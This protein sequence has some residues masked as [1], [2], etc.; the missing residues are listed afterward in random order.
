MID[1]GWAVWASVLLG[2][3]AASPPV[4]APEPVPPEPPPVA[5][6][7]AVAPAPEPPPFP[8]ERVV[9]V[10]GV[11][12]GGVVV[13][14]LAGVRLVTG[15][16]TIALV[17][18]DG[19]VRAAHR[20]AFG[21]SAGGAFVGADH[22]AVG[23]ADANGFRSPWADDVLRWDLDHDTLTQLAVLGYLPPSFAHFGEVAVVGID[24]G[25]AF[26][27]RGSFEIWEG[28][29]GTVVWPASRPDWAALVAPETD[30]VRGL[31]VLRA[32]MIES[33][34]VEGTV[35][36]VGATELAALENE[37]DGALRLVRLP[38][39]TPVVVEGLLPGEVVVDTIA[40][41]DLSY[42]RFRGPDGERDLEL[43]SFR[44]V[45]AEP[46]DFVHAA[47]LFDVGPHGIRS[48]EF[49]P[50]SSRIALATSTRTI[51][52]GPGGIE[53][54]F[55]GGRR[56][57][58]VGSEALL[59]VDGLY[60]PLGEPSRDGRSTLTPAR[61]GDAICTPSG[62]R[63]RCLRSVEDSGDWELYDAAHPRRVLGTIP[64]SSDG[65]LVPEVLAPGARYVR[66]TDE[67]GRSVIVSLPGGERTVF[68]SD[69]L[70][71]ADAWIFV[72]TDS[73]GEEPRLVRIPYDGGDSTERE[74]G[75]TPWGLGI[76]DDG[77]VI[78]V[79]DGAAEVILTAT[80]ETER[81]IERDAAEPTHHWTCSADGLF[82]DGVSGYEAVPDP[83]CPPDFDYE[84]A[85]FVVSFDRAFT[86][87]GSLGDE[88][89][90][91]R[92]ADGAEIS[93]RISDAGVLVSG[94]GGVFAGE[95]DLL[96]HVVVR[97]PGPVRA[98]AI[99]FG[100]DARARF[101]RPEL[102]AAFFSGAPLP[103]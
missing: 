63:R 55:G 92:T 32:G 87:E 91:R 100:A 59:R 29:W 36:L 67:W 70:E 5:E 27:G 24:E 19:H 73:D 41:G 10:D 60:R 89:H 33:E 72:E 97:D 93:V 81:T 66:G 82:D 9:L 40:R 78:L 17:G 85:S 75:E 53:H 44:W 11:R 90:V 20:L 54:H 21:S 68:E 84:R 102:L 61:D 14:E 48:F 46:H 74:L 31:L 98:A 69:W 96:D 62:R 25:L 83:A 101:E 49:A 65:A 86:A 3:G 103:E 88:I 16:G 12:S 52:L 35:V 34:E 30:T 23:S 4:A 1:R 77:H 39:R 13:D 26:V 28:A 8:S 80:L 99:T 71:L 64:P 56:V 7:T 37:A 94:P 50:T 47:P 95:G 38:E 18:A 45:A 58:W 57:S 6:M 15:E 22:A 51:V 43:P 76:L 2:C 42:V 79:L